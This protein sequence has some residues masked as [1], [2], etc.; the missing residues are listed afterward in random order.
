MQ[1][2]QR[3]RTEV[4]RLFIQKKR[5]IDTKVTGNKE[6]IY[7]V[8]ILPSCEKLKIVLEREKNVKFSLFYITLD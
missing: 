2:F 8:P 6:S 1:F 3:Y 5:P 7:E 4:A